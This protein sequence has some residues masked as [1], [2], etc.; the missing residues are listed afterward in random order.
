M[1]T[2]IRIPLVI[3]RIII[4]LPFLLLILLTPLLPL[5]LMN[6]VVLVVCIDLSQRAARLYRHS[7]DDPV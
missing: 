3:C 2:G 4:I 5:L 6:L 7:A 1:M